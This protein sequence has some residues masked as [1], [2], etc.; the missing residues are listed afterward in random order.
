M[1]K[2]LIDQGDNESLKVLKFGKDWV[3]TLFRRMGFKKL[4]AITGKV[5]IPKGARKETE[6]IYQYDIVTKIETYDIPHQLVFK[7][8]QTPLKYILSSRYTME[9]S[10][11]KSL[12]IAGSGGKGAIT[13]TFIINLLENLLS[14]QLIYGV[15]QI[16]AYRKLISQRVFHSV[17]IRNITAMRKKHK[18]LLMK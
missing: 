2:V 9:K 6:L 3:Q 17:P 5:I 18:R 8:D 14:M 11:G 1:A 12:A 13:A 15:K 16:E 7:M 4:A 10:A